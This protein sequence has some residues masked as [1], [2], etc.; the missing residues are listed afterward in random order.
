MKKRILLLLFLFFSALILADFFFSPSVSPNMKKTS[1]P[2]LHSLHGDSIGLSC[3]A[4]HSGAQTGREAFLPS[5]ADCMDCHRL[6][7]TE[8][9]GI[10]VLDSILES[11]PDFPWKRKSRLPSHVV[12]HHG[13]HAKASVSCQECHSGEGA[14]DRGEAPLMLMNDCLSCHRGDRG[15]APSATDC[16]SCHR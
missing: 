11:S 7:L 2:F 16:A 1:I 4:C 14:W 15:F 13:V 10:A 9:P 3:E 5:K 6:P 8:S 12:F